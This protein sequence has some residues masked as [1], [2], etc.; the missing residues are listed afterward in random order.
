MTN[1]IDAEG[2]AV[3]TSAGRSFLPWSG[4]PRVA[5]TEECFLW[6]WHKGAVQY[7]PKRVLSPEQL[8]TVRRVVRLHGPD[9]ASLRGVIGVGSSPESAEPDQPTAAG[10]GPATGARSGSDSAAVT[11]QSEVSRLVRVALKHPDDAWRDA[12]RIDQQWRSLHYRSAPDLDRARAEY[13]RFRTIL[14]GRGVEIEWLGPDE[15][16]GLDSIYVRDAA[17][18]T[19]GG[20]VLCNMGKRARRAEPEA[21]AE[22]YRARGIPVLGAISDPGRLEGGDVVWLGPAPWRW[23]WATAPI[24]REHAS[25]GSWPGT[26]WTTSSWCPSPT[27]RARTTS[28]TSCPC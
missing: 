9:E 19:D 7:T 11:A 13:D 14:H 26:I 16:T 4:M 24:R 18:V 12:A 2:V 17:V 10:H 6:Y 15:S 3:D 8:A 20:V 22:H 1:V 25:S 21:Q 5:E 28:S 27:G 23:G